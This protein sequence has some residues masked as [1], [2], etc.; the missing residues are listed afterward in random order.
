MTTTP[1]PV[2]DVE[3]ATR[4]ATE[5]AVSLRHRLHQMPELGYE[6]FQTAATIRAE[7]DALGIAHVDG[8]PDAPTATV[9]WI[10]DASGAK[11]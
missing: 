9:A 5:R 2:T 10:G 3:D 11:P 8:V 1:A 6:E 4:R 7:L